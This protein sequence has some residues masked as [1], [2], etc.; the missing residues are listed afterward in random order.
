M[1][2]LTGNEAKA[3]LSPVLKWAGGK[4]QL[5]PVIQRLLPDGFSTYYEPFLGGGALLF[6]LQPAHAAVNDINPELINVYEVIRDNVDE[7][8]KKLRGME[9]TQA[10]FYE[11][12]AWDRKADYQQMSKIERAARILYLNRTCFN[13][14]YRVNQSGYFNVPFGRY[15]NPDIVN[16]DNLKAVSAYLNGNQI[17]L[18]CGSYK[19]ILTDVKENSFV[20]L[21]PPYDPVKD[22]SFTSYAKDG[23]TRQDQIELRE[24][25]DEL[26]RKG[27]KFMLSNSSTDSIRQQYAAYKILTVPCRRNINSNGKDRAAV[28]EVIVTNY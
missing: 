2:N 16:E 27:I 8:I 20:Y 25:C 23:F 26:N 1:N 22:T 10:A 5:L 11:I 3:S 13:G 14:L 12:R 18:N 7:L 19:E 24:M 17:E 28:D 15:K 21:D 4:R 6:A 9:N